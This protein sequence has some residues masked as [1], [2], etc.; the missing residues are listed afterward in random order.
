MTS[1]ANFIWR[2]H[3]VLH[4][5]NNMVVPGSLMLLAGSLIVYRHMTQV[6]NHGTDN[7][8]TFLAMTL[9][10]MI[11]LVALEC[12]VMS[13]ADPVG[14]F[15]KFA[16]PV[17]LMHSVFLFL[18]ICQYPLYAQ[19]YVFFSVLGFAGAVVTMSKGFKQRWFNIFQYPAVWKLV[20][21]AFVAAAFTV[22]A[23]AY[24]APVW[25]RRL[26]GY[27]W[28]LF[29]SVLTTTNHYVELMAFVPAVWMMYNEDKSGQHTT[30]VESKD[31]KRTSTAFFL[32]LVIFYF[33][34]D[35]VDAWETKFRSPLSSAAHVAHFMLLLDFAFYILAHVYNP[36]KLMGELR[37]WLPADLACAV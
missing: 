16:A 8:K 24:F 17:T 13:C 18:R 5:K 19:G 23:D 35:I 34:E 10:Q 36:E 9:I 15:C 7:L 25:R 27:W 20:A 12:K 32:F 6:N 21:L 4:R 33:T 29:K 22:S 28:K 3:E 11:P 14:L 2:S 37:K 30:Q 31:T 1:A 26:R